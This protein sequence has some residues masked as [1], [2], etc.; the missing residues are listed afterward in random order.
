VL[1]ISLVWSWRVSPILQHA[2]KTQLSS[3]EKRRHLNAV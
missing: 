1:F 2:I 3:F